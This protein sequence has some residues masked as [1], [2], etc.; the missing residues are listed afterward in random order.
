[1]SFVKIAL[2]NWSMQERMRVPVPNTSANT[3]HER[4]L[5]CRLFV[6]GVKFFT[7]DPLILM[8]ESRLISLY[9]QGCSNEANQE[10]QMRLSPLDFKKTPDQ[11]YSYLNAIFRV[12]IFP[13][14]IS[15]NDHKKS[16]FLTVI[17]PPFPVHEDRKSTRLNSSHW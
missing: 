14:P 16:V 1:M 13:T 5:P 6:L 17:N 12:V 11:L 2:Q 4:S 7:Q 9:R 15:R 3:A 10:T 8:Y